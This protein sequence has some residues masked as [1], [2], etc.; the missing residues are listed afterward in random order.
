MQHIYAQENAHNNDDFLSTHPLASRICFILPLPYDS[1]LLF[2][3]LQILLLLLVVQIP[4]H[5]CPWFAINCSPLAASPTPRHPIDQVTYLHRRH[6][7]HQVSSLT[8]LHIDQKNNWQKILLK[9]P[10]KSIYA[11]YTT[12]KTPES[13]WVHIRALCT[14]CYRHIDT[15]CNTP[16]IATADLPPPPLWAQP[17]KFR[18]GQGWRRA[19]KS[20]DPWDVLFCAPLTSLTCVF[21]VYA[22]N[23][24][25]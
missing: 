12:H 15:P 8:H 16:R 2:T 23:T 19:E 9:G 14:C 7:Q 17:I 5:S 24:L 3:Y 25:F 22:L 4:I 10:F 20:P 18:C 21:A 1:T 11:G 13:C 6:Q